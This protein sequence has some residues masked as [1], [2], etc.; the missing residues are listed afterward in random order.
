MNIPYQEGILNC[1]L[2]NTMLLGKFSTCGQIFEKYVAEAR[3]F[4]LTRVSTPL[5]EPIFLRQED[6]T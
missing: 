6:L 4:L 5:L 2:H 1:L 3:N